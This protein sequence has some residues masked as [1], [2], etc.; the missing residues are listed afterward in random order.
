MPM[1][2]TGQFVVFTLDRGL[3]AVHLSAVGRIV[4]V[5]EITPLPGAPE[6][7]LGVINVAGKI[8]PVLDVRS[9]FRLAKRETNLSDQLIIANALKRSVAL[10]VDSV[11]GVIERSVT[12]VTAAEDVLP[13]TEYVEGVLRLEEGIVLIHDLDKFLSLDEEEALDDA[14]G[15]R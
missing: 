6:I 12:E 10:I 4:S 3:Y 14:M 5:V 9:R 13:N 2:D 11:T 15:R 1:N 7:V 8:I